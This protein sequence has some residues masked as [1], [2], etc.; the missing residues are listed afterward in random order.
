MRARVQQ[1]PVPTDSFLHDQV[2][3]R[4]AYADCFMVRIAGTVTFSAYVEA[5]Y[6]T[7][8][9]KA[10]RLI[11]RLLARQPS[12]D[13]QARELAMGTRDTFAVWRVERRSPTE[14]LLVEGRTC[15]WFRILP[16]GSDG[17]H[18][19]VLMFGSAIFA[20]KKARGG[21][22]QLGI[23]FK[24]LIGPHLIYS[25]LL[26]AAARRRLIRTLAQPNP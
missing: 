19:T 3:M 22:P 4:N 1:I 10:E 11:L 5:F 25:R 12:T 20:A 23:W 6:T 21:K 15:S 16:P 8:I 7:P 14:L 17:E 2:L 9:F 24:L 26:L 18:N 13:Q